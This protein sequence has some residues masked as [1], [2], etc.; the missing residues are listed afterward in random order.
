M[1][2]KHFN[3]IV[4][5]SVM[6]S[7]KSTMR[8]SISYPG[9]HAFYRL[10]HFPTQDNCVKAIEQLYTVLRYLAAN[11][12]GDDPKVQRAY[13]R[14]FHDLFGDSVSWTMIRNQ[15]ELGIL[16]VFLK[17]FKLLEILSHYT[18]DGAVRVLGL[19][20]VQFNY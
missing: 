7:F 19:V 4:V 11:D 6:N 14:A 15:P 5:P 18:F 2:S 12:A 16:I 9:V 17:G 1:V 20:E 8:S 10:Y 13:N 3:M